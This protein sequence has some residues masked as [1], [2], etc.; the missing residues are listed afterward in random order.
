MDAMPPVMRNKFKSRI[1]E[2]SRESAERDGA[3]ERS[4]ST[5]STPTEKGHGH[6]RRQGV[7]GSIR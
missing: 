2:L 5:S 4:K 6:P 3:E 1:N 7:G